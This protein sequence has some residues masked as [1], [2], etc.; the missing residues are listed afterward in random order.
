MGLD[1]YLSDGP[2]SDD[3]PLPAE[4]KS[5]KYPN[6]LCGK[7]YLRSSYN[8]SGFNRVVGN[9]IGKDLFWVFG[10]QG[11]DDMQP[12]QEDLADMEKRA[13]QLIAELRGAE[14]L[15][16]SCVAHNFFEG[17]SQR[18]EEEA[19]A[20]VK[21]EVSKPKKERNYR[22]WSSKD[23]LFVLDGLKIVAAIPGVSALKSPGV[24][25][26][27]GAD[28]EWYY[29]AAEIVL[30]FIGYAKTMKHPVIGWSG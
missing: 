12:T 19:L 13:M 14:P 22:E 16:V 30:E 24:H 1:I 2:M 10:Q 20:L 3:G 26:V 5:D 18:G 15:R 29:Q 23:G 4:V 9:L 11:E 28:L 8:D 25:L 27:Y 21:L 6:H 7:T 17:I